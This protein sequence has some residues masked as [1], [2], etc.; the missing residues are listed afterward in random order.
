MK[1]IYN[2]IV[3][4]LL[5]TFVYLV[6]GLDVA[7]ICL[8]VA[9]VLDYLSGVTKA[10]VTKQLSS[11]TGFRGIVKKVAVLMIV[12]LAVLVD[13]VTG[14]T[15]AIRTLVIYYFVANEGLSI[16]ENLGQAGVPIPQSIKKALKALKKEN[17]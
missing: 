10:Y 1:E 7:M 11:Q 12:M 13:R 8:L 6:G 9:I 17:K 4:T 15:G 14:E 2:G 3:A 16:I 5:T